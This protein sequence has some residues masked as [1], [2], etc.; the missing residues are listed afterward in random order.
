MMSYKN[1]MSFENNNIHTP[2]K[3]QNAIFKKFST[4]YFKM[5]IEAAIF[6]GNKLYQHDPND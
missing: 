4:F 6:T 3:K 5:P 2:K 1:P